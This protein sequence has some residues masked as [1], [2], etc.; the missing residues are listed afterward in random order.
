MTRKCSGYMPS[1]HRCLCLHVPCRYIMPVC[2]YV[3]TSVW[4]YVCMHPIVWCCVFVLLYRMILCFLSCI[5]FYCSVLYVTIA[6]RM[7]WYATVLYC[8]VLHCVALPWHVWCILYFLNW[9]VYVWMQV[10]MDAK[11]YVHA[12]LFLHKPMV[13]W[14]NN[15]WPP[16]SPPGGHGPCSRCS[17]HLQ[18][19]LHHCEGM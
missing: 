6:Y 11:I 14:M 4:M 1:M 2:L 17:W 18:T 12:P 13:P 3:C 7:V 15:S 16:L 5:V 10:G 9:H 8:I 19:S